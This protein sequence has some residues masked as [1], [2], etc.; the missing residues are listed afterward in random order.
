MYVMLNLQDRGYSHKAIQKIDKNKVLFIVGPRRSG[1]THL[2]NE[3]T[4]EN[5]L[6][7]GPSFKRF[8]CDIHNVRCS[9][10]NKSAK[11]VQE[12]ISK[13]RLVIF[14]EAQNMSNLDSIIEGITLLKD[15][16]EKDSNTHRIIIT[17]SSLSQRKPRYLNRINLKYVIFH[18]MPLSILEIIG[19]SE[20]PNDINL[21]RAMRFGFYPEVWNSNDE[22]A[23]DVLEELVHEHLY[24]SILDNQQ[25]NKTKSLHELL[26]QLALNIGEEISIS[27][28]AKY[29]DLDN[30]TVER[31]LNLLIESFVIFRLGALNRRSKNEVKA[32]DKYYFWDIG[33]R[34]CLIDNYGLVANRVDRQALWENLCL[35]ERKKAALFREQ[36][37]PSFFWRT[38]DDQHIDLI[39]EEDTWLIPYNFRWNDFQDIDTLDTKMQTPSAFKKLYGIETLTQVSQTNL[40]D[41][42]NE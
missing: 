5:I 18:V 3:M 28:L 26:R 12:L 15:D 16:D 9:L 10:E 40:K 36:S 31:Y 33:V 23:K 22:D 39:E 11:E 37:F 13:Y 8:N 27:K 19:N 42:L 17:L 7:P 14:E 6:V 21:D 20:K 38:H 34:N 1:K 25:I 2:I 4:D 35:A 32:R 29:C 41:F 24:R 30:K